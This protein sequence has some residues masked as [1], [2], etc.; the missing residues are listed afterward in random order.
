MNDVMYYYLRDRKLNEKDKK[1]KKGQPFGVVAMRLNED[2]TINRGVS[3][4]SPRDRYDKKA[5]RGIAYKRLI[6]AEEYEKSIPF[7][8]YTGELG[9][10]NLTNPPF[11]DRS[12]YRVEPTEF[13]HRMLYKPEDR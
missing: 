7:G 9:M 1:A 10:M 12:S 11:A 5:G 8:E 6:D 13:E 2:G 3:V 4:C